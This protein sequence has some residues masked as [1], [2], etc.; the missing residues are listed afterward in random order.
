MTPEITIGAASI[1]GSLI[2]ATAAVR[3][4]VSPAPV[5]GRHR[6]DRSVHCR[7]CGTTRATVVRGQLLLCTV[8]HRIGG[9]R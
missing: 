7:E 1:M 8:G 2:A 6:R 9:G 3:W 5:R 4:A